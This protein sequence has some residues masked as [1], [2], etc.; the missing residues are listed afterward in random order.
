MVEW[1]NQNFKAPDITMRWDDN[2][3]WDDNATWSDDSENAY[4]FGGPFNARQSLVRHFSDR[5]DDASITAAVE[6]LEANGVT[7]WA[8]RQNGMSYGGSDAHG[9]TETRDN[10]TDDLNAKNQDEIRQKLNAVVAA[11]DEI[12]AL[13]VALPTFDGSIGHNKPPED[14]GVPPYSTEDRDFLQRE[15]AE[16]KR[17]VL[18]KDTN[19]DKIQDKTQKIETRYQK[20]GDWLLKKVELFADESLKSIAGKMPEIAG[21][22]YFHDSINNLIS[23]V[24]AYILAA[25]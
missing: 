7:D 5:Y 8:P 15:I 2:A 1:F 4:K 20:I 13:L 22:I 19:F 3:V 14:V 6:R 10:R 16:I 23:A 12:S 21:F 9:S 17:L 11:V 24:K 25:M 18:S